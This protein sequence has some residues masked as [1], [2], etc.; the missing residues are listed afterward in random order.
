MPCDVE[1]VRITAGLKSWEA[2]KA[3]LLELMVEGKIY[4]RKTT[5]SWIFW[6]KEKASGGCPALPDPPAEEG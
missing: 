4:G 2:T 3:M 5:K 6:Q 1:N